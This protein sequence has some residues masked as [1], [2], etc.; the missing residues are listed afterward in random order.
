MRLRSNFPVGSTQ[1][2]VRRAQWRAMGFTESDMQ[3]P[4]IAVVNSSSDLSVCFS[5]LDELAA[6]VKEEI[7]QAGGLAFEIRT[8]APSDFITSAGR[9]GRYLMPARDLIVNDIEVA[10]EGA[11]LDGMVCLSSCDKTTPA[12]LMAAARLNVPTIVVTGGY[13]Q[14]GTLDGKQV[15]IEDVF[16]KVGAVSAGSMGLGELCRMTDVAVC[17]VGVCAGMGTANTMHLASEALGM[18][19]PGSTPAV[20]NGDKVVRYAKEAGRRI[21]SLIEENLRP[22]DV[23]TPAAFENAVV[24]CLAVGGSVNMVRHLQAVAVEAECDVDLY[25]L[26]DR[27]GP[28]TPLL[29]AVRPNGT[30]RIEEL[31][32]AGGTRA[33]LRQLGDLIDV[34]QISVSGESIGKSLNDV[35]VNDQI[36]RH[37]TSPLKPGPSLILMRGNLAPGGGLLKVGARGTEI[38][39]HGSAQ[40][41]DSQEDALSALSAG[42][43][44]PGSVVVLRGLGPVGGP[45]VASASWFVAA[46]HGS[47]L[48]SSVAVLTDGQLSGLNHGVVIGQIS[49]ESKAGGPLGLVCDGD[50]IDI[51]VPSRR[52]ELCISVAEFE[53]RSTQ[54]LAPSLPREIGWLGMYQQLVEPLTSGAVL[55]R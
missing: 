43:I 14:H 51:D 2:A 18:T 53:S 7:R 32:A 52:V 17:G 31:E 4:K 29:C 55:R 41:F 34:D 6:T 19:L 8:V 47:G 45:G 11:Q 26:L 13:Q 40:V 22:R 16:E 42:S 50:P 49:P 54:W 1:W 35:C 39:F 10:V 5:H 37:N 23:L 36:V 15:D 27:V 21:V 20:G 9:S 28:T 3:K 46:L 33:V 38:A 12:H 30:T 48:G 24:A 25:E 44:K